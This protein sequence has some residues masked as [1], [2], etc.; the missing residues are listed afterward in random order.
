MRN[1][2]RLFVGFIVLFAGVAIMPAPRVFADC[3]N[4]TTCTKSGVRDIPNGCSISTDASGNP[5]YTQKYQTIYFSCFNTACGGTIDGYL[6]NE[7]TGEEYSQ[8]FP[9][10]CCD[11]NVNTGACGPDATGGCSGSCG[12]GGSCY[13][14]GGG[15]CYCSQGGS[16]CAGE[17]YTDCTKGCQGGE[18]GSQCGT[19]TNGDPKYDCTRCCQY[20]SPGQTTLLAPVN[21]STVVSPVTF[22]WYGPGDWGQDCTDPIRRYQL[23]LASPANP[24][25]TIIRTMD[26]PQVTSVQKTGSNI[27]I[28]GTSLGSVGASV[29]VRLD[30]QSAAHLYSSTYQSMASYFGT[31]ARSVRVP[32]SDM[33]GFDPAGYHHFTKVLPHCSGVT[34]GPSEDLNA[35]KTKFIAEGTWAD[36]GALDCKKVDV[37]VRYNELKSLDTTGVVTQAGGVDTITIPA[38]ALGGVDGT[39]I[40]AKIKSEYLYPHFFHKAALLRGFVCYK[41]QIS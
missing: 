36:G 4:G 11:S 15:A 17:K 34:E 16:G 38:S 29:G 10:S 20:Q 12:G 19:D 1:W 22:S 7:V 31:Y 32:L 25:L 8:N 28:T 24:T 3:P 18:T 27:V 13:Q 26:A 33:D 6:C 21:Q 9:V 40:Y 37:T 23:K 5:I 41:R 35:E 39:H 2:G 14:T 30:Y